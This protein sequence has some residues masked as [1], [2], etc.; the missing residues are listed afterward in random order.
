MHG[1]K[2][3]QLA[4]KVTE[5]LFDKEVDLAIAQPAK[6]LDEVIDKISS[7][8]TGAKRKE[9]LNEAEQLKTNT[10]Q[11]RSWVRA[12]T[13]GVMKYFEGKYSID[14]L[15]KGFMDQGRIILINMAILSESDQHY[16][17]YEI[18][19]KIKRKA[20]A[21]FKARGTTR[22]GLVVLDEGPR[23]APQHGDDEVTEVIRDAFNTTRK[24]GIGWTIISQRIT[25]ISK[26]IIAQCHTKYV[27]RGMGIGAD[28]DY[29]K[30]FFREDGLVAYE[31]LSL[32]GGFFW[33]AAGHHVNYG[34][35]SQYVAFETFGG[36][37]TQALMDE[38]P[39]I[40]RNK[41]K[42]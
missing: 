20:E 6:V 15:V 8:Y 41:S 16:V 34:M 18:F 10:A 19:S 35:G 21:D 31:Q 22:N 32:R 5:E 37:A 33:L 39:H 26:D 36:D 1:E 28:R 12:Y 23:W 2:S 29:M 38:N 30:E 42:H 11:N 9:K 7:N 25:A 40:W 24:L 17:M 14:E 3:Q 27:G 4:D 13:S